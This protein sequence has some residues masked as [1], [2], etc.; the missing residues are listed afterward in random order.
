M[1]E[2][3]RRIE[4]ALTRHARQELAPPGVRR[5]AVVMP[6]Y[7]AG[8]EHF[9]LLT[10]RSEHVAHHRGQICFPGGAV[11]PEDAHSLAAA[12]RETEEEIGIARADVRILGALD[13]VHTVVSNFVVTPF[14]GLIPHPYPLRLN[15]REIAELV[16]VP[17]ATFRDPARLRAE[18]RADRP[19]PLLFY[20]CGDHEVWGATA[21]IINNFIEIVFGE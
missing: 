8:E 3:E 15:A 12:L 14:V 9:L 5:A 17:L 6:L 20:D 4:E 21:R 11:D 2:I 1:H 19:L 18:E 13:D 10:R 16:L 7:R